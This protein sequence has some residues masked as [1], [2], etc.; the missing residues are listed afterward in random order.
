MTTP[1]PHPSRTDGDTDDDTDDV[2]RRLRELDIANDCAPGTK[3]EP[4]GE[5]ARP[6]DDPDR[7]AREASP[8]TRRR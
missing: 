7:A 8:P 3:T 6:E 5:P 1:Q 4:P 2:V